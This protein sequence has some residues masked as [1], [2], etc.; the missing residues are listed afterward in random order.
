MKENWRQLREEE[1]I[2]TQDLLRDVKLTFFDNNLKKQLTHLTF[3]AELSGDS[4][5]VLCT[6][7][8]KKPYDNA[9]SALCKNFFKGRDALY[10]ALRELE[11]KKYLVRLACCTKSS[12]GSLGTKWFYSDFPTETLKEEALTWAKQNKISVS[13]LG[14]KK[15]T[16]TK[17]KK[18]N[19]R[20]REVNIKLRF[21]ILK[22]D[23]FICQY[24][25]GKAPE[26][27]LHVDH[28]I[29]VDCGGSDEDNNLITSCSDCNLGKSNI[30]YFGEK[31]NTEEEEN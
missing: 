6:L 15:V 2:R 20:K 30:N 22:R 4:L 23:N 14:N 31:Y 16:I 3:D 5:F 10:S 7:F 21:K 27:E 29:P 18:K 19:R 28:I 24:C 8:L 25:G 26:V 12:Y 1:V 11:E 17:N 9:M 13:I